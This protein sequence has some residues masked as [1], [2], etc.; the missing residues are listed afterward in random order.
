MQYLPLV[1]EIVLIYFQLTKTHNYF[2]LFDHLTILLAFLIDLDI[3]ALLEIVQ[4]VTCYPYQTNLTLYEFP[5]QILLMDQNTLLQ[6]ELRCGTPYVSIYAYH[7]MMVYYLHTTM[8]NHNPEYPIESVY[9]PYT[10]LRQALTLS[11]YHTLHLIV[12]FCL[13]QV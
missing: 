4:K 9:Q 3:L 2:F 6:L 1:L 11:M 7:L 10:F 12:L 5:F 8:L 13:S